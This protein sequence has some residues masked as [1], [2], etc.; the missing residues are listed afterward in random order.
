MIKT[1]YPPRTFAPTRIRM[2]MSSA[3]TANV[4]DITLNTIPWPKLSGRFATAPIQAPAVMDGTRSLE[5]IEKEAILATLKASGGNKAEAAR[6]LGITRKTL[7]N[8]LKA[9]RLD[10]PSP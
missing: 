1:P 10:V 4:S 2:R 5:E 9:Y 3:K 8:K 7:H 6:R